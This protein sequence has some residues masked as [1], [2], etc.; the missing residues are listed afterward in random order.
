MLSLNTSFWITSFVVASGFLALGH[1]TYIIH[2]SILIST[3]W[4]SKQD[5]NLTIL[6][7]TVYNTVAHMLIHTESH[8]TLASTF[9]HNISGSV[10]VSGDCLLS[11][12]LRMS[13]FL[14]PESP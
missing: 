8:I 1:Y 7:F 2:H 9:E 6:A 10:F 11:F 5:V 4:H 14:V 3:S 12:S 13:C